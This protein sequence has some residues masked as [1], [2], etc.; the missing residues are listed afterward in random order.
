MMRSTEFRCWREFLGLTK[1][2]CADQFGCTPVQITIWERRDSEIPAYADTM[3]RAWLDHASQVV[4][5]LTVS[6]LGRRVLAP[7]DAHPGGDLGG[8]P[9]SWHRAIAARVAE[10]TGYPIEA[11]V[12][13]TGVTVREA[14]L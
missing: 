4:G 5:K 7:T 11:K 2:W 3:M 1:A 10:R 9:P 8:M 13:S 6:D 14:D 12:Y